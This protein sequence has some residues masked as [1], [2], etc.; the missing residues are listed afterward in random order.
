M[1]H[2]RVVKEPVSLTQD[3]RDFDFVSP[4]ESVLTLPGDEK[5]REVL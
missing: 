3:F 1:G 4:W 2:R 5:A